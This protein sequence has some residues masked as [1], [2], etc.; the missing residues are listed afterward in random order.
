MTTYINDIICK[1]PPCIT[2]LLN[3]AYLPPHHQKPKTK[4]NAIASKATKQE[5]QTRKVYINFQ[6][7]ITTIN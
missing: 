1:L 7:D 3:E 6:L 2:E 5:K 4:P